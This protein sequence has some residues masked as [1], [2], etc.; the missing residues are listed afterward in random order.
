ML[1]PCSLLRPHLAY[2]CV[3][4]SAGVPS[5]YRV[6]VVTTTCPRFIKGGLVRPSILVFAREACLSRNLRRP[7]SPISRVAGIGHLALHI[8]AHNANRA[9][10]P[11][12]PCFL[13]VSTRPHNPYYLEP[14]GIS[15]TVARSFRLSPVPALLVGKCTLTVFY[16]PLG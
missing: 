11:V 3:S 7:V 9:R 14:L 8:D 5:S 16:Q 15:V 4:G 13:V 6:L 10:G 12:F 1:K 2:L